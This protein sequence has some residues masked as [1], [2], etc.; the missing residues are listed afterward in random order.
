MADENGKAK[1][2]DSFREHMANQWRTVTEGLLLDLQADFPAL[3]SVLV[4]NALA[5]PLILPSTLV[6][7]RRPL[8]IVVSIRR[9]QFGA[10]ARWP[11]KDLRGILEVIETDLQNDCGPW[12]L[13][14]R[15]RE[16][17]ERKWTCV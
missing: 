9:S 17:L 5:R 1:L 3:R 15:Q 6:V 10:I 7:E 13:D 11:G 2:A 14:W 8:E 12:E 16:R 4:G